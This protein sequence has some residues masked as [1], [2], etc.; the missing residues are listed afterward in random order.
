MSVARVMDTHREAEGYSSRSLEPSQRP[1]IAQIM[2]LPKGKWDRT[3]Q[4]PLQLLLES[5][6]GVE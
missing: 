2:A 3:Q 1:A 6:S 4:G 5:G